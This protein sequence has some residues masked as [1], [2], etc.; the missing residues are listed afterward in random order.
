M[1]KK[2]HIAAKVLRDLT[3]HFAGKEQELFIT[4]D[5]GPTPEVT[6]WVLSVL[7]EYDAKA[8]FFCIGK[9][10]KK[11]PEL[12]QQILNEGHSV[13]NHSYAHPKGWLVR[14][15][16]YYNDIDKAAEL[17]DS[18]LFRPPFG[19]IGP[20][21]IHKLKQDFRIIM[22][23]VLSKDYD[24]NV[25]REKCF[26]NVMNY[27]ESGSIIVFHDTTKA[28]KNLKYALPEMLKEFTEQGYTFNSIEYN[29]F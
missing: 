26:Q 1:S 14:N 20:F 25:S 28:E 17:I 12:Y 15:N 9:N 8:T 7:K 27:A 11:H 18:D 29:S 10:V 3:W 16:R 13:G 4:F 5:D 21:Q 19:K 6:P 24:K 23:D 2:E 22:W